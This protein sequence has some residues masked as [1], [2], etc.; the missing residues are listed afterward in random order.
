[1][2]IMESLKKLIVLTGAG[3]S[4][5]S[6]IATFR[7][8]GGLWE[9]RRVEEVATP[10]AFRSNPCLVL[11]F[12]NQR[13]KNVL[14]S[15]PNRG[16]VILK[17]LEDVFDVTIITQNIDDLHERAGSSHIIHLH[18]ELVKARSTAEPSLISKIE[19]ADLNLGDKCPKGSQLRPHIVWFGEGV[20]L[21]EDA[22]MEVESADVIIV[23]GTSMQVYPAASLVEFAKPGVP[24]YLVDPN[25]PK[26]SIENLQIIAKGASEGLAL[27]ASS[28]SPR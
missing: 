11:D 3:M 2:S 28:I 21:M 25:P 12:Y 24:I 8:S 14:E 20:P 13:R 6:G 5:E 1:M 7:G 18:G 15:E 26:V 23:V 9:G 27:V 16:H 17:E 19:G 10:A 4:A 22:I